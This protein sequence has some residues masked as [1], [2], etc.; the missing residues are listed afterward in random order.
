[1]RSK[2]TIHFEGYW[3][4][5][6][7]TDP[8]PSL[9]PRGASGYTFALGDEN[10]FDAIIRLH[11]DE[12][13]PKDFRE[14]WPPANY[15]AT[16][17]LSKTA[18]TDKERFGI[19]V[20]KVKLDGADYQPGNDALVSG[21]VR[22]LPS[23]GRLKGPRFELRNTIIFNAGNDNGIFMP[24]DPF[25]IS[26][27]GNSSAEDLCIERDDLLNPDQP[28]EHIWEISDSEIYRRRCPREFYSD[29]DEALEAIGLDTA[30]AGLPYDQ[31]FQQRK[32]WL[33]LK[34]AQVDSEIACKGVKSIDATDLEVQRGALLNRLYV[35]RQFTSDDVG[36]RLGTRLGLMARW[37]H[38]L[39]GNNIM[40]RGTEVLEGRVLA[41]FDDEW[42]TRY[43][44]GAYDGD[45]M[46][47]Y[48]RGF[49][50]V[51]FERN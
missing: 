47:G 35:I 50:E 26:I 23:G 48:M 43:W 36:N 13:D 7:A 21:K 4:C 25:H 44:M 34:L 6:Q 10:D 32:E 3:Q 2:L 39:C 49:L 41:G 24:I 11:D 33:E 28:E 46:R 31:Y 27:E 45:T 16:H 14:A 18:G 20:S 19:F 9:D 42:S 38:T 51:P 17:P 1:M 30:A 40:T 12:I 15:P 37:E 29:A 5:R 22:W 8:D